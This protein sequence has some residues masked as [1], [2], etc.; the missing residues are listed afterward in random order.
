[1]SKEWIQKNLSGIIVSSFVAV[2]LYALGAYISSTIAKEMK[3]YVPT[4]LWT[5]WAQERGEWRGQV[6]QRLKTLESESIK[7]RDEILNELRENAKQIAVQ[8]ALLAD[9]KEQLK[10]HMSERPK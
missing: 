1:M 7:Q 4:S 9:M 3:N 5:Q 6:D 2:A 8:T 10:T